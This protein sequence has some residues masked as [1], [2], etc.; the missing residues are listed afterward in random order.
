MSRNI[1]VAEPSPELQ[2]KIIRARQAIAEQE[3]RVIKCPYC[4]H[5][6]IVVFG[7]TKGHVQ[8]KCKICGRETVFNVLEMRRMRRLQTYYSVFTEIK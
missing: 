7:D 6:S 3:P 2:R 1:R 4:R 8:A 5:N